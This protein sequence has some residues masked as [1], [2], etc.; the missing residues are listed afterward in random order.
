MYFAKP[1]INAVE[2]VGFEIS[3][4]GDFIE[5]ADTIELIRDSAVLKI[6]KERVSLE[7]ERG[8]VNAL[9]AQRGSLN[10][11]IEA[12]KS[13]VS[14]EQGKLK[15]VEIQRDE[16]TVRH[17]EVVRAISNEEARLVGIKAEISRSSSTRSRLA[18]S[19]SE[20]TAKL[21]ELQSNIHLFPSELS[22]FS[23]Q[24]ATDSRTFFFLSL[25]PSLLGSKP[26]QRLEGVRLS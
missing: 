17:A 24:G 3:Q 12:L 23:R 5:F 26:N 2:L 20:K 10:Q 21:R 7:D 13:A 19:V 11:D 22:D 14:R 6:N 4:A 8:K 15:R 1:F 25:I 9:Q 16:V 18:K